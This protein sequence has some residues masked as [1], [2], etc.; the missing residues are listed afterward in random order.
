MIEQGN[1]C[2]KEQDANCE[3]NADCNYNAKCH[4][5]SKMCIC[6]NGQTNYPACMQSVP[7]HNN[8]KDQCQ[9]RLCH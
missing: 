8:C 2:L 6:K 5:V 4:P 7:T 3:S 9:G 1:M